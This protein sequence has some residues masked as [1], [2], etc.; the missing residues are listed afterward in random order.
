MESIG[1][2]TI[3]LH[4]HLLNLRAPTARLRPQ[5]KSPI[6]ALMPPTRLNTLRR[7]LQPALKDIIRNPHAQWHTTNRE[8]L[9]RPIRTRAH[10]LI[11][12]VSRGL[13]IRRAIRLD[14]HRVEH[15]LGRKGIEAPVHA[16]EHP[17]DRT[18]EHGVPQALEVARYARADG[19]QLVG[20]GDVWVV[21]VAQVAGDAVEFF[22]DE[23]EG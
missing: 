3:H 16:Q 12:H 19:A 9:T 20:D 13:V 11:P 17:A 7:R 2:I 4:D 15:V 23:R 21:G 18:V 22:G 14:L 5:S 10:S 6:T 1:T 8:Q